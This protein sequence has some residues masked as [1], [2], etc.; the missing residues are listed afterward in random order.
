MGE[1]YKGL[2]MNNFIVFRSFLDYVIYEQANEI[3]IKVF[4]AGHNHNP[5]T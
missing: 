5:I 1:N 2:F 3:A 4:F